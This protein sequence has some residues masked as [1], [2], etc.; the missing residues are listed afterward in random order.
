MDLRRLL[1]AVGAGTLGLVTSTV[2]L[3]SSALAALAAPGTLAVTRTADDV[4]KLR[5]VWKAVPGA[6]HY[7]AD[8]IAGDVQTVIDL[9]ATTTEYMI[10]APNP[11]TT[12]KVRIGAVDTSGAVANTGYYT[13]KALTPSAVTGMATGR[14][15]DGGTATASWKSPAWGGYSPLTGYRAVFTRMIDNVV[16]AERTGTEA[17][18]R[19]PNASPERAYTLSLTTINAYGACVT[20][21]SLVDRFR[22]AEPTN[23]VVQRLADSPDQVSVVWKAPAGTPSPTYY[24]IG[25]GT[26]TIS[27]L[28]KVDASA[29]SATLA[30]SADKPWIVELKAYNEN[31]GSNAVSGAIPATAA[32]ASPEPPTETPS[33]PAPADPAPSSVAPSSAAPSDAAPAPSEA[34]PSVAPSSVA[35]SSMAPSD[36]APSSAAPATSEA[37]PEPTVAPAPSDK[38]PPK[39]TATL[40]QQPVD[41]WFSKPV[42]IRFTCTDDSGSVDCPEPVVADT[43]GAD[44]QFSG[45]AKDA[46]GNITTT[47]VTVNIDQKA[48]H[49]TA[50]VVNAPTATGWHTSVPTIHY[51]CSDTGSLIASCPADTPVTTEGPEQVVTGTAVDRAGNTATARLTVDIDTTAPEVSAAID[52][53]PNSAGWYRTAPT[54]RY[55]CADTGSGVRVCPSDPT[56]TTDGAGQVVTGTVIDRAGNTAATSVTVNVDRTAPRITADLIG[57]PNAAGWYRTPPTVHF[58]CGD[59]ASGVDSCP[60]DVVVDTDGGRQVVTGTAVDKAGNTADASYVVNVDR[61]APR[62]TAALT[63]TPNAAGWYRTAPTVRYTCADDT[64]GIVSCPAETTVNGDGAAKVVTGAATDVAGNTADATVTAKVDRTAPAVSVV[65]A[66]DGAVYGPDFNPNLSCSTTDPVSGVATAAVLSRSENRG[67]YTV[68]CSGA[69]DKAGNTTAPAQVTYTVKLTVPWLVELTR[70]YA[71]GASANTLQQLENDLT[72]G[73]YTA[74]I[75]KVTAMTNG[76]TVQYGT[77]QLSTRAVQQITA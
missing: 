62:V 51:V 14:A 50:T 64:S 18:F 24:Q 35:P 6:D 67:T 61:T 23:V 7:T 8:I 75:A 4:Y 74:Y 27:R 43:D 38:T 28:V 70:K 65:G 17:T 47:T 71:S 20:T 3:P 63:G 66:T 76:A 30:L 55:T 37:A 21:K 41:D 68:K 42:T 59:A 52:Q 9:P 19:Y 44:Q 53:T 46:A 36:P 11:C 49:I 72:A 5:V 1:V 10:D 29:R 12:F 31:G 22:P 32:P 48:P 2:A 69:V 57:T 45:T 15:D 60:A 33:D 56:V 77:R 25:Y 16:L 40:S 39:I 26:E 13:L 58:T 73:R 54:V 34:A